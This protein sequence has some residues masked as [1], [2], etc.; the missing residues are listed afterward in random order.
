MMKIVVKISL[1]TDKGQYLLHDMLMTVDNLVKAVG[2]EDGSGHEIEILT[3]RKSPQIIKGEN[4]ADGRIVG[5]EPHDARPGEHQFQLGVEV[6]AP[7]QLRTPV[8]LL[9]NLI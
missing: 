1:G 6:V 8:G 5:L 2:M 4:V 3:E 7:A 9:E